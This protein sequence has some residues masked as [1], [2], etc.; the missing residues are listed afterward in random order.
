MPYCT[1]AGGC[2]TPPGSICRVC[3][4]GPVQA[5]HWASA[6]TDPA[7][8]ALWRPVGI[9]GFVSYVVRGRRAARCGDP[10]DSRCT[11][12]RT[13]PLHP[14]ACCASP[15]MVP[16]HAHAIVHR[17][18]KP[19]NILITGADTVQLADFGSARLLED[20][21]DDWFQSSAGTPAFHAPE[22]CSSAF[23][24][25]SHPRMPR[26][27]SLRGPV[28]RHA[29]ADVGAHA[30]AP[31][32]PGRVGTRAATVTRYRARPV[33]VWA[34]G[35]TLFT[36]AAGAM[37]FPTAVPIMVLYQHIV[38]D[39]YDGAACPPRHPTAF[40]GFANARVRAPRASVERE[41]VLTA[42]LCGLLRFLRRWKPFC[43]APWPR[44]P[45]F[46][47]PP[48]PWP[49]GSAPSGRRPRAV[50]ALTPPLP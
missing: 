42:G 17:D 14:L 28:L 1:V 3:W 13:H 22:L 32:A 12:T 21:D 24:V 7:S 11:R 18:I 4:R 25:H 9:G 16:V 19:E 48:T 34:L 49:Y 45:R 44:T 40:A 29:S 5:G 36:L 31:A 43:A 30:P 41:R 47:R 8:E 10:A 27:R 6:S 37:P 50:R 39:E 46:A 15:R 35:L 20:A 26:A 23:A 38:Q 2:A 33:D